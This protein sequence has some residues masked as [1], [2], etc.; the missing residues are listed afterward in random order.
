MASSHA[1]MAFARPPGPT[2]QIGTFRCTRTGR[3]AAPELSRVKASV[4][5]NE[6]SGASN[7]PSTWSPIRPCPQRADALDA[8]EVM[9]YGRSQVFGNSMFHAGMH[10][11]DR[12]DY[13]TA[14]DAEHDRYL[15]SLRVLIFSAVAILALS[16]VIHPALAGAAL[17]LVPIIV[18]GAPQ[19]YQRQDP[20][21]PTQSDSVHVALNPHIGTERD[22]NA[23]AATGR[24]RISVGLRRC[25]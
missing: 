22:M 19:P 7:P 9:R 25:R 16:V 20:R 23:S 11:D 17:A 24:D 1:L 21:L 14:L 13:W 5:A 2:E 6:V 12:P 15:R 4:S 3:A 8:R 10:T 18:L